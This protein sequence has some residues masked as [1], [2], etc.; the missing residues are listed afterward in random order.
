MNYRKVNNLVGWI[1]GLIATFVYLKTMESTVS[2]WDCG[3]FISCGYKVEV[4]HSPGAPF[5]MLIQRLFGLLAGGNLAKVAILINS[6][7][8]IASGLTILFLFW[9]ITHFAKKM[10]SPGIEEPDSR[11]LT[12]I[13]GAGLVGALAYTFSDTFWFSAVEAEVYAT[14]SFFTALVFWAILKWEHV[15]NNKHADRWLVFIA[16]IIG[17]SICTHLLNLLTIPALAVLYYYRRYES[18][19]TGAIIAFLIGCVLL[20]I[21]QFGVI[22]GIPWL[23]FKFDYFFCQ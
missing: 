1:T 5:F 23:A 19:N 6:W 7:S 9:T 13:M 2:F 21:V 12:V 18:T 11:Q 20:A 16:Y 4:G 8:A 3:E 10:V 17:L 15:A 22:Q 14:S